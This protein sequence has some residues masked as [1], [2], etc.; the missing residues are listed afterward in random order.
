MALVI[1]RPSLLAACTGN[2]IT[3]SPY[4][5]WAKGG[6]GKEEHVHVVPC[7]DTYR[8]VGPL[9]QQVGL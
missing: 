9:Q 4:K 3:L 1:M 8:W 5:F 6:E 7:P 2:L